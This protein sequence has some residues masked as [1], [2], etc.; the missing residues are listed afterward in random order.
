MTAFP[1]DQIGRFQVERLV[2]VQGSPDCDSNECTRGPGGRCMGYHCPL[3]DAPTNMY[4]HHNCA[5][6]TDVDASKETEA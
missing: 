3:C 6:Q 1:G 4:G 2:A 5:R